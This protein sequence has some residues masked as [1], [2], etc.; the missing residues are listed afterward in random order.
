M[1]CSALVQ[2][3]GGATEVV[4]DENLR[5]L[6]QTRDNAAFAY[7]RENTRAI[8]CMRS[9]LVPAVSDYKVVRAGFPLYIIRASAADARIGVLEVSGG[10]FRFR[11]LQGE[12]T[13]DEKQRL[14][15]RLDDI[16]EASRAPG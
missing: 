12:L 6:E 7:K 10:Q 3:E 14:L 8:R 4:N 1:A 13:A 15:A 5:V 2:V 16:Q 9:D 11:M